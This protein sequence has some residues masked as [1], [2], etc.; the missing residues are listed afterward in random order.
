MNL[1]TYCLASL[2]HFRDVVISCKDEFKVTNIKAVEV[3]D[4]VIKVETIL[5]FS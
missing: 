4:I 2:L 5:T 3:V 1:K